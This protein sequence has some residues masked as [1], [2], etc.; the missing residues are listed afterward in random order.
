MMAATSIELDPNE[1]T[2]EA[3]FEVSC[4]QEYDER[5]HLCWHVEGAEVEY[6]Q[7]GGLRL[8]R[9][10]ACDAWGKSRIEALEEDAA[11]DFNVNEWAEEEAA[12]LGDWRYEQYRDRLSLP[13]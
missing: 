11:K 13:N 3:F 6:V 9:S 7:M 8:T 1:L 2:C 12:A 5:G 10:Q 4:T